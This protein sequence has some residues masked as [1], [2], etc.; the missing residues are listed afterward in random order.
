MPCCKSSGLLNENP[1]LLT[2][3]PSSMV[4]DV[5]RQR[6]SKPSGK[7]IPQTCQCQESKPS[8]PRQNL[9]WCHGDGAIVTWGHA[10]FGGDSSAVRDQLN[11]VQQILSRVPTAIQESYIAVQ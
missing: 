2:L 5:F 1:E 7:I 3:L 11:C 10:D 6:T 9:G 4:Q 8:G